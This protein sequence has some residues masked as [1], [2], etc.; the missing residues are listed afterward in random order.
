[1]TLSV[2]P[3]NTKSGQLTKFGSLRHRCLF[4]L[5]IPLNKGQVSSDAPFKPDILP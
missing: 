1:L 4:S 3:R 2:G 5:S